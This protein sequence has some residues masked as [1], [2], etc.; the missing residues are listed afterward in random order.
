MAEGL[1][2]Y[3]FVNAEQILVPFEFGDNYSIYLIVGSC[4]GGFSGAVVHGYFVKR[5]KAKKKFKYLIIQAQILMI[6]SFA[7]F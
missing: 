3:F 2:G 5:I 7:T 4:T 1:A 6:I